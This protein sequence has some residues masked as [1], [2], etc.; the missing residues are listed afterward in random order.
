VNATSKGAV[1]V[2]SD[3]NG[4]KTIYVD[5]SAGGTQLA[6]NNP[7][8]Y[9]R[10]DTASRVDV[11]DIAAEASTAWDL[12]LKR[13]VLFT[14]DGDAGPGSGG[15]VLLDGKAFDSVTSAD[16]QGATFATE[17]FFDAQC[18]PQTDP[19]GEVLTTL[20]RR[21]D[22][23]QQQH[24]LSPH[25]GTYL[26]KSAAGKVYKLAIESYYATPDGGTSSEG[27]FYILKIAAL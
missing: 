23:N 9:L 27:G 12:S 6:Q 16:A 14:N 2:L 8:I 15:A 26:V 13:A 20:S 11:T 24:T 1:T 7:R 17:T 4:V 25:P 22:Y 10:L 19:T 21:Y 3:A 18:N 5:A